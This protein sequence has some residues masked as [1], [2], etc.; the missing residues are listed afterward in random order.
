[1][2]KGKERKE[3][4][5][6]RLGRTQIERPASPLIWMHGASVGESRLLA[7]ILKL[8]RKRRLGLNAVLT[9]QTLTSADMITG[10]QM[11]GAI[12]QMAPVDAP[13]A[14]SR[15]LDHWKPDAAVFAEGE[16]WPNMLAGLRRTATPAALINA[17]MTASSLSGWRKRRESAQELFGT[18]RFIG[19]ADVTTADELGDLLKRRIDTV[20]NLKQAMP[21]TP[22][23]ATK[24]ADWRA[25]ARL[26]LLAASTHEGEDEIA[27]DAFARV[28]HRAPEALLVVAPR[29]PER[30]EA[31]CGKVQDRGLSYQ[32]RSQDRK[33]P[34]PGTAVLVADT[35]GEMGFWY[36]LADAVMLGGANREDVGGHNPFEPVQLGKRVWTGHFGY[37]FRRA[38]DDLAAL[39]AVVF[40]DSPESLAEFWAS[41]IANPAAAEIRSEAV[42][43]YFAKARAPL[44]TTLDA[45]LDLLP[46]DPSDA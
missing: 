41:A 44:D 26:V 16:I 9:T 36:E 12:H 2:R 31:I 17:R 42:E 19:A 24:V 7:D 20:G 43:A 10:L 5:S 34:S 23:H 45:I 8:V 40:G 1:M 22:S 38:L 28:R 25:D 27:L 29:H 14:V 35:M 18:F 37:N 4:L 15:F 13:G 3:R 33:A 21:I 39:G 46:E 30:G 6:E 11:P 32:L